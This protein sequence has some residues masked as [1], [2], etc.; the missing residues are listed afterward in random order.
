MTKRFKSLS[1]ARLRHLAN[2][3]EAKARKREERIA[4]GWEPEPRH[5]R[6]ERWLEVAFRDTRT[7]ETTGWQEL[8]SGREAARWT[9]RLLKEWTPTPGGLRP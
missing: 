1:L 2:M 8:A 7:G 4:A 5:V 9:R 6:G 3:R